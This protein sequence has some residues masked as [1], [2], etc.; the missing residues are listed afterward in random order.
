MIEVMFFSFLAYAILQVVCLRTMKGGW[1]VAAKVSAAVGVCVVVYTSIAAW[2]GSNLF[3]IALLLSAP[4]LLSFTLVLLIANKLLS[5][6]KP[7]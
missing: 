5:Y 4:Y 3:P 6:R 7:S 1:L 2:M